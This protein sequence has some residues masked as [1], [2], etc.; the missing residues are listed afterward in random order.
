MT[1]NPSSAKPAWVQLYEARRPSGE[2]KTRTPG[3]PPAPV[4]RRKIGLTLSQGEIHELEQWQER[5]SSLL[6]RKVSL[7]ETAGILARVCSARLEYITNGKNQ[8][9]LADLVD[10][11]IGRE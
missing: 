7:G 11:M 1:P 2:V 10:R 5:F 6:R 9:N 3:R 4:P 8:E